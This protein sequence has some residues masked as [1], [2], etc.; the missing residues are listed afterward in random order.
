[1]PDLLLLDNT[2]LSNF[3][4]VG[5]IAL[6]EQVLGHRAATVTEVVREYQRGVLLR[7]VPEINW[8][9]LTVHHLVP[10]E[11][12]LYR[13]FLR[14]LSAGE[15]ACLAVAYTRKMSVVTDDRDARQIAIQYGIPKTGTIGLLVQAIQ[16]QKVTLNQGNQI[17]QQMI[18]TGYRSPLD[19]LDTLL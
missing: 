9:W 11:I 15:A 7:R 4:L 14:R 8:Q 12:A 6:L 10:D 3:A 13:A 18:S 16:V 5:H 1:M 2:V 17:L 19:A